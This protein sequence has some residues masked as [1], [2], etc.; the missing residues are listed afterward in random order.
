MKEI[1]SNIFGKVLVIGC[2]SF[3]LVSS[4]QVKADSLENVIADAPDGI[5]LEDSFNLNPVGNN[6]H[7]KIVQNKNGND[8]CILTDNNKSQMAALW[9]KADYL[10]D[11]NKDFTA[12]MQLY[13][14]DKGT[15]AADGITFTLHNDPR[16]NEAFSKSDKGG[17]LGIY[18]SQKVKNT[19]DAVNEAVQNSFAIE[20]DTHQ[21]TGKNN[22]YDENSGGSTPGANHIAATLPSSLDTYD[23]QRGLFG[24]TLKVKIRH[25]LLSEPIN[26][27]NGALSN[28][29]W[30]DFKIEY[31]HT[32]NL[33]TY[34]FD[35]TTR[36]AQVS[37]DIFGSDY[38]YWGFTGTTGGNSAIN[39]VVF[40]ELPEIVS[41]EATT[42]IL[43]NGESILNKQ[44][45]VG[46]ELTYSLKVNYIEGMENW[47]DIV[48]DIALNPYVDYIPNTLSI[49]YPD[50]S[51]NENVEPTY[52]AEHHLIIPELSHDL[53]D[54]DRTVEISFKVKVKEIN[55]DDTVIPVADVTE[56]IGD[57]YMVAPYE[58]DYL[59]LNTKSLIPEIK[60]ADNLSNQT[61]SLFPANKELVIAGQWKDKTSDKVN[62]YCQLNGQEN[63]LGEN[64]ANVNKD[65]L[66]DF[67]Y[68]IPLES[69]HLGE[70]QVT[71]YVKNEQGYVSNIEQFTIVLNEGFVKFKTIDPEISFQNM[72]ISGEATRSATEKEVNV[73][74]EDTTG[75]SDHWKLAVRQAVPFAN[76]S[77]SLATDLNYQMNDSQ[78][79]ITDNQTVLP[80]TQE[81]EMD[82][83]LVQD[84]DHQFSL[85]VYPGGY[86]GKYASELEWMII[87][88][89]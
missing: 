76:A 22:A 37:R 28:G 53:G 75:M 3:L 86:A 79:L 46:D 18:P 87:T 49:I 5:K 62:L 25:N 32:A 34:T 64:V 83:S 19:Q 59:I 26:L 17:A 51:A 12:R 65:V 81:N 7:A 70:N 13:L 54:A 21:N 33:F 55:S 42:D 80:V 88:A 66:T 67:S 23:I 52:D 27:P 35:G 15:S 73:V 84:A 77:G 82:Y 9:S 8:V 11:L 4:Q 36:T 68:P 1:L 6:S 14:G 41:A 48:P 45:N 61:I 74:V 20:F 69:L 47:E 71:V 50:S 29:A 2:F 78:L 38:V 24:N 57:N 85:S 43:K 56:F 44:V 39:A 10:L 60:L 30:H 40:S 31:D 89:P 72:A 58:T 63:L 16:G